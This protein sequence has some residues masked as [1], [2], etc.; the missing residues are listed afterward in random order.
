[1]KFDFDLKM[2]E[3]TH[4]I[5]QSSV[6]NNPPQIMPNLLTYIILE[7]I[8]NI[9]KEVIFNLI[10]VEQWMNKLMI[11]VLKDITLKVDKPK[12]NFIRS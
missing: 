11:F 2:C 9:T 5:S 7:H 4:V 3:T 10:I 12:T 6:V 1:M 8:F